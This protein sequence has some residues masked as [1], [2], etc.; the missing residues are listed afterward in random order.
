MRF[1]L[2]FIIL[3]ERKKLQMT[4]KMKVVK[5]VLLGVMNGQLE[6]KHDNSL[7]SISHYY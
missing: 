3:P 5:Q 1:N 4:T 6:N 7:D 2:D